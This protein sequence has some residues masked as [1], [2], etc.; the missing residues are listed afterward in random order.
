M[1]VLLKNLK[2]EVDLLDGAGAS[3]FS[4]IASDTADFLEDLRALEKSLMAEIASSDSQGNGL[5]N[6]DSRDGIIASSL[7]LPVFANSTNSNST[8]SNSTNS[9][10]TSTHTNSSALPTVQAA[11]GKWYNQ[12]I[13]SLKTYNHQISKYV[14]NVATS[15]K[16]RVDL[17]SAY[18]FPLLLDSFPTQSDTE[19]LANARN[20]QELVKSIIVHLLKS[21]HD[22]AVT[23]LLRDCHVDERMEG[24]M[25]GQFLQLHRILDELK[26][27]HEL[28]SALQ[29]LQ[30]QNPAPKSRMEQIL[31]KLHLLQF[32]LYLG[33]DES[34]ARAVRALVYGKTH[35]PKYFMNYIDEIAPAMALFL[36]HPVRLIFH[37]QLRHNIIGAF[38]QGVNSRPG[39]ATRM[40]RFLID[41]LQNSDT[42]DLRQDVFDTLAHEFAVEFC[43]GMTLSGESAL[44]ESLL[45]GFVNLPNF[46]KYSQ[47]QKRIGR[48]QDEVPSELPF[49]LPDKNHFL[50]RHHPIFICPISKEQLVP[51]ST[52]VLA[53]DDDLRDRKRRAVFVSPTEKLVPMANPV[54]VFDHCRHL[55]L[56]DSVRILTK[57]GTEVFKCHYCYKKH[58][59]QDVSDAYFIDL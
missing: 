58:K 53:S 38:A 7:K 15:S 2:K 33:N 11:S 45:A 34:S 13:S 28:G 54:V 36:C 12:S 10:S 9:N 27:Q 46:Y 37:E 19:L 41:L 44:F 4:S 30:S 35:F 20:R 49:Q 32:V 21:G 16:Y 52:R 14:K 50:F 47:L 17:D 25:A 56:K 5:G 8:N 1:T 22:R 31:L 40:D 23:D 29:W 18:T 3:A 51:L 6:G 24:V 59:L 48:S 43:A 42:M 26:V 55:A 39:K 57:G